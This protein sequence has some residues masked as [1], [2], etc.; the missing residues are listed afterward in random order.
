MCHFMTVSVNMLYS[1]TYIV[2]NGGMMD[3]RWAAED[4][5]RSCCGIIEVLP[6]NMPWGD[7]RKPQKTSVRIASIPTD[8]LIIPE[9]HV[10]IFTAMA[11]SSETRWKW[12]GPKREHCFCIQHLLWDVTFRDSVKSQ[13]NN[14]SQKRERG[15]ERERYC[16]QNM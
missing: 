8:I 16:R 14:M 5:K 13:S 12:K 3:E 7:L 4:L 1:R 11:P 2:S 6:C 15:R 9:I 10:K